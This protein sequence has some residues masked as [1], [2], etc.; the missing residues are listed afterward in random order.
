LRQIEELKELRKN[1]NLL[2]KD[3]QE[4]IAS[5]TKLLDELSSLSKKNTTV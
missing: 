3:Q 4:K 5:E 1:G 2:D